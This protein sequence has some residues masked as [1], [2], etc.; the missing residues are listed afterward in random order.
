MQICKKLLPNEKK[1]KCE[2]VNTIG[3][4]IRRLAVPNI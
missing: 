2:N 3:A 1:E 4:E